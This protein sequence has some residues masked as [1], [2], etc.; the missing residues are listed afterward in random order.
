M[1][2][3]AAPAAPPATLPSELFLQAVG[4]LGARHPLRTSQAIYN[5]QGVMLLGAGAAVDPETYRRLVSHRLTAA[6]D[7]CIEAESSV[8]GAVLRESAEAAMER[9]AFFAQMG[10]PARVRTMLLEAMGSIPLPKRIALH[11]AVARHLRP[12]WFEH[13]VLMGLLCAHLVRE[14]GGMQHDV[15]MAAA[16][17]VLHDIGMLHL[18]PALL[19]SPDALTGD[20]LKPLYAHPA[21]ST[22]GMGRSSDYQK[23]V[24]R[25]VNEHHERLDGSGYPRGLTCAQMS[26]LGRLLSLAEVVTAMYDGSRQFP[27]QR[28]SLMLRMSPGSYDASLAPSIH[29][30]LRGVPMPPEASSAP[31]SESIETLRRLDGLLTDWATAIGAMWPR[32]QT[33]EKKLLQPISDSADGLRRMLNEAGVT[34]GQL[35][36][37]ADGADEDPALRIELWVLA[38]E[39]QWQLRATAHHLQRRWRAGESRLDYPPLLAMWLEQVK[40]LGGP[41]RA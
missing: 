28:V 34:P 1:P 37:I 19:D 22:T 8:T 12:S 13:G 10:Q 25:A 23:D 24:L 29:R 18:E 7:E 31:A 11:L 26:P 32:L 40:A 20:E 39:L 2:A 17:G 41:A 14:G 27:E 30:L 36:L 15:G 4:Q 35:A 6:L 3:A 9:W 38:R 16:A 5:T 21:L 33:P